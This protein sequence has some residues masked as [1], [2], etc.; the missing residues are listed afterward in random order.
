MKMPAS[1]A[2]S[3]GETKGTLGSRRWPGSR[4]ATDAVAPPS[5]LPQAIASMAATRKP[6]IFQGNLAF[7]TI[8]K[9]SYQ[10]K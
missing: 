4:A 8:K 3:R 5:R 1:M 10:T 9:Q 6:S 7:E 2:R